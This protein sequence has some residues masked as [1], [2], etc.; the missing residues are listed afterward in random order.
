MRVLFVSDVV[1]EAGCA[2]LRRTL[3]GFKKVKGVDFCVVNG[4]NSARGNGL[5]P[6]S[7]EHLLA[8][9]A[10]AVTGG[11]HTLRRPEICELLDDDRYPALRP[12]NLHRSAPGRGLLVLEKRGLRLGVANLLG[13]VYMDPCGNPFDAAD[14]ICKEFASAGAVC[15][16]VD[17]HAEATSE[18]RALGF[19][20]D[21]RVSAVLGTHTHV[22][23]ADERIM[24]NGTAYI[25]DLGMCGPDDSVLGIKTENIIEKLTTHMPVKFDFSENH[26]TLHGA[27]FDYDTDM[28]KVV[29][30]ERF[31]R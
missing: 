19:Y 20:L 29:R 11:N 9:G 22:Q 7:L 15:T 5:T 1:G 3:P 21:G 6:A 13:A 14:E 17:L 2:F 12:Y 8:S 10:D 18:K 31:V 26:V 23:T 30:V 27:V 24:P 16:L 28:K 25:T 4:E